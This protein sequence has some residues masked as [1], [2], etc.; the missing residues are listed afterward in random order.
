MFKIVARAA[1][2]AGL[3]T[4]AACAAP[5][6]PAPPPPPI[7]VPA[8]APPRPIPP[9]GAATGMYIPPK[10]VDDVRLTPNRGLESDE[11][12]WNFR[13]AFNVAALNCLQ[14]K[15]L[16]FA[17][18]YKNY[19]DAHRTMLNQVNLRLDTTYRSRYPA[20]DPKRIRDTSSTDLYNYFSLPPVTSGFCDLMLD[21]G[22]QAALV[23]PEELPAFSARALGLIDD[24]FIEFYDNYAEYQRRLAAW[25]ELYGRLGRV[26]VENPGQSN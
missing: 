22:P 21:L 11:T 20:G 3:T 26:T 24:L 2:L 9:L 13:S 25:E 16:R 15:Y 10:G 7:I 4:L 12:V 6:P 19:L 23:P 14:P 18:D 17:D 5:P 8:S 1:L